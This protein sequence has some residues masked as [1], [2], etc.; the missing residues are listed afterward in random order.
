MQVLLKFCKLSTNFN[1]FPNFQLSIA[2]HSHRCPSD[3]WN[4]RRT[5]RISDQ[6]LLTVAQTLIDWMESRNEHASSRASGAIQRQNVK[7]SDAPSRCLQR[8]AY[9][10]SP[11]TIA[12]TEERW[13]DPTKTRRAPFRLTKSGHSPSTDASAATKLSAIRSSRARKTVHGAEMFRN[14]SVSSENQIKFRFWLLKSHFQMSTVEVRHRSSTELS[15]FRPT[16]LITEPPLSTSASRTSNSTAFREDCVRKMA[17]GGTNHRSALKLLVQFRTSTNTWLLPPE[18][19]SSVRLPCSPAQRAEI[20]SGTTREPAWPMEIGLERIQ[21][22]N[23][24]LKFQGWLCVLDAT[25]GF[26][27]YFDFS[28]TGRKFFKNF[29]WRCASNVKLNTKLHTSSTK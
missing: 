5:Q 29:F 16:P 13:S 14:V 2:S 3:P 17:L 20:W 25:R 15:H 19:D 21:F 11:E 23:V 27:N 6:K 26:E 8:T 9:C 22:A 24:S 7:K 28:K 10:R 18:S 4:T 1:E 12:C